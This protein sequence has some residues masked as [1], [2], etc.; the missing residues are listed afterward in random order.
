MGFR[1]LQALCAGLH[2][3]LQHDSDPEKVTHYAEGKEEMQFSHAL[4]WSFLKQKHRKKGIK[5]KEGFEKST[6]QSSLWNLESNKS[7]VLVYVYLGSPVAFA[8][9]KNL[10]FLGSDT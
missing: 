3:Q 1:P 6:T 9:D 10:L 8:L 7:N 2:L 5:A 4:Q